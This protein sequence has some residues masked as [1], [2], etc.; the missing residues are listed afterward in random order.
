MRDTYY[1]GPVEVGP[2]LGALGLT[3]YPSFR[4]QSPFP[5]IEIGTVQNAL[6]SS[7]S[8]FDAENRYI[9]NDNLTIIRGLHAFTTGGEVRYL[10]RNEGGYP[11]GLIQFEP[12][13]TALNGTGF[14][15]GQAV[16]IPAGTGS[17][18]ASFL[19][20][21]PHFINI[22]YPIESAYRWEQVG[23]FI[24]DDWRMTRKLT[25]NLGLRYDIQVPRS[26]AH[27][28]LSSMDPTL[29][30]PDA[31]NLPGAFEFFGSGTGRN[32]QDRLSNISY[33]GI[34][35]RIGFAYAPSSDAKTSIR[36]G[37]AIT[38]PIGNDN[39]E[40]S[41]GSAL[42]GVG[43]TGLAMLNAPGDYVGSPAYYW[44]NAYPQSGYAG[45]TID[46][47]I[48]VGNDNPPMIYPKAGTPP[49]QFNWSLQVERQLPARMVAT[50]GWVGMHSYHLGE[51]SKPNEVNPTMAQ[52]K[53]SSAAAAAG[54]PLNQFLTLPVT[55]PRVQAAGITSPWSGFVSVFGAGATAAQALRPFPQYGSVDNPLNPIGSVSYNGLQTSLQKHLSEGLTALISYTFSKTI[56]NADSNYGPSAEAENAIYAG[57]FFQDY[58]NSR[59]QR[60]VTSSDIPHVLSISYTYELPFGTHK[61]FLNHG[62]VTD[63]FVGGWSVSSIQQYQ[64][65]RPIH[66]EY[67]AFGAN[68]PYDA[69]DDYE[70]RPNFVPGQP[71]R[72]PQYRRSCSGAITEVT[73]RQP[74]QFYINPAAFTPPPA[75][76]FGNVPNLI[77][78]LRM[79]AFYDED[80]SVSKRTSIHENLDLQIQA[81]FFNAFNRV[82]FSNGGDAQTFILNAAPPNLST[83]SLA[84]SATVF[85]IMTSQQN[86]PRTIQFGM[87]L[88]F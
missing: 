3:G 47:G 70:F 78:G 4:S 68:N 48:L 26:D 38:H 45:G 20:G 60:S 86:A 63:R 83:A 74:C 16:S 15:N 88:E 56:G 75:G 29:P 28:N 67:D 22:D 37:F 40:E 30:N 21:A 25:L 57:T 64:S 71:L 39:A 33:K 11:A 84:N 55:D 73:G 17:P 14:A 1:S 59:A 65:G 27:G 49:T 2:G 52:E 7:Y 10:Q 50:V 44:D 58:Y 62:S 85:G 31:G 41:I 5:E 54:L 8:G 51:W 87:K 32:G 69:G 82:V 77:A 42:Y 76:G 9:I 72:N 19:M 36:G 53:Y 18:A 24:Q 81:N 66:I 35:P 43:F 6:G 61:K 80:L 13:Q 79:P 46:P 23:M 12:T 34:Q